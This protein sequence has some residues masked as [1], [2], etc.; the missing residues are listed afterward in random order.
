VPP[1]S[2]ED[3]SVNLIIV[4]VTREQSENE[5]KISKEFISNML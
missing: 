4:T 5:T 2:T 1:S 3:E